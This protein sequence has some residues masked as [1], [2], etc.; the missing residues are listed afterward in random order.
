MTRKIEHFLSHV[1]PTTTTNEPHSRREAF[2]ERLKNER[3]RLQLTQAEAAE[4]CG[5]RREMWGKYERGQTDPGCMVL[6]H[7]SALHADVLY[8]LTGRKEPT[9]P[10]L[11][12][13][14]NAVLLTAACH[15]VATELRR[16]G[17][18]KNAPIETQFAVAVRIA[19]TLY[20]SPDLHTSGDSYLDTIQA[21]AKGA[22][23]MEWQAWLKR[24]KVDD[25]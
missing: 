5:V 6:E 25:A 10:D 16:L 18:R 2:G 1:E 23:L 24:S 14:V 3:E 20:N 7:F 19:V 13:T 9:R 11:P 17:V 15:A 4:A 12:G 22:A 8:I 21:M